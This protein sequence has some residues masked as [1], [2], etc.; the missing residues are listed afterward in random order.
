MRALDPEA[1][2]PVT[3]RRGLLLFTMALRE[4]FFV[5][6]GDPPFGVAVLKTLQLGNLDGSCMDQCG[7]RVRVGQQSL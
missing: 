2:V 5:G 6:S 3:Y 4:S 1:E 7:T